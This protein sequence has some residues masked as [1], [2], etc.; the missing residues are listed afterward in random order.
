MGGALQELGN[1]MAAKDLPALRIAKTKLGRE[2]LRRRWLLD[3]AKW[4]SLGGPEEPDDMELFSEVLAAQA[5]ER[6]LRE[7]EIMRHIAAQ[8]LAEEH[9]GWNEMDSEARRQLL[10]S[11]GLWR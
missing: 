5:E 9:P 7:S 11:K 6:E 4:L 10:I 3:L 2:L 8:K 1:L